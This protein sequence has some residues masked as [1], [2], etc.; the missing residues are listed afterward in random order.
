M[1]QEM[2]KIQFESK[3]EISAI[4]KALE[5]SPKKDDETVKRLI[6]LLNV[7]EMCW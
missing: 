2:D 5:V 7:M 1:Q 6:D 4:I 3:A